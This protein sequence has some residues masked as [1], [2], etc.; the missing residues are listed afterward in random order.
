V[1][2]EWYIL[3]LVEGKIEF[4]RKEDYKSNFYPHNVANSGK[5][6]FYVGISM[7]DLYGC[8]KDMR[9]LLDRM[10]DFFTLLHPPPASLPRYSSPTCRTHL[11]TDPTI[12]TTT[13]LHRQPIIHPESLLFVGQKNVT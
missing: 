3:L 5:E 9:S 6:D 4:S 2:R 10:L 12:E 1:L 11:K 8:Q 7:L 13:C